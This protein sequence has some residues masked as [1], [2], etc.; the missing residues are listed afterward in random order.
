[1]NCYS[2]RVIIKKWLLFKSLFS[3]EESWILFLMKSS[4]LG[5]IINEGT[6]TLHCIRL[7]VMYVNADIID[8]SLE[9]QD[10]EWNAKKKKKII[11]VSHLPQK[12]LITQTRGGR[13]K[14]LLSTGGGVLEVNIPLFWHRCLKKRKEAKILQCHI[15]ASFRRTFRR[16]K[17]KRHVSK[18]NQYN[19]RKTGRKKLAVGQKSVFRDFWMRV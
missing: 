1:M 14:G 11:R 6:K 8:F 7:C 15:K 19:T 18:G 17:K 5:Y 2:L 13:R 4:R 3:L 9:K 12:P 10:K 16:R